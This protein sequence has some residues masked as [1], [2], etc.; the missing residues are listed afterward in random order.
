MNN[1]ISFITHHVELLCL[2]AGSTTLSFIW[3][4]VFNRE[5]MNAKWWDALLAAVAAT[6]TGII[7]T[8][9]FGAVESG[10]QS[11]GAMSLFG[12]VFIVPLFCLI[13]AKIKK[14]PLGDV[15]DV[16]T[17]VL[18]ISLV[19]ARINC[20]IQGCCY[21]KQI[22]DTEYSYPTRQIEIGFNV[23]FIGV[24]IFLIL[25]NKMQKKIYLIYLV[26]YGFFRFI[27]E[28]FRYS[29][30]TAPFHN[31]HIWSFLSLTIGIA[32]LII[33]HYLNKQKELNEGKTKKR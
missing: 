28:F 8:I 3:V 18:V 15:L 9:L 33:L 14:L 13:Y 32:L 16:F 27:L 2:M 24:A 21:G 6:I 1:M 30:T 10:F 4:F 31:G 22:G 19:F 5:K 29:D 17:V 12:S 20:L 26:A 7:G 25:K 23:I 11:L